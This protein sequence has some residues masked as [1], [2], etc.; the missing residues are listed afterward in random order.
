MVIL[1]ITFYASGKQSGTLHF[2]A[3]YGWSQKIATFCTS[4]YLY[5]RVIKTLTANT[6]NRLKKYDAFWS[7]GVFK[8]PKYGLRVNYCGGGCQ[9]EILN[10]L[11]FL[12]NEALA[13]SRGG[14]GKISMHSFRGG[15]AKHSVRLSRGANLSVHDFR[16]CTTSTRK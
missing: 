2:D 13:F 4:Q 1:I 5:V 7:S 6:S 12:A 8:D 16:I 15:R 14:G 11:L 9:A 10:L 3:T